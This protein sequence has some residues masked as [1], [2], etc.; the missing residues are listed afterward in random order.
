MVPE[1]EL[2]LKA[3]IAALM[4]ALVTNG[5]LCEECLRARSGLPRTSFDAALAG[6]EHGFDLRPL[7]ASR[8]EACGQVRLVLSVA[9]DPWDRY[10]AFD[11]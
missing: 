9:R 5:P 1:G 11:P 4:R 2:E 8:C 3:E 10:S 7:H 6:I